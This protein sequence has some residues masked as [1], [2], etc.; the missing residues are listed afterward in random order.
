MKRSLIVAGTLILAI[1]LIV[2]HSVLVWARVPATPPEPSYIEL[3]DTPTVVDGAFAEWVLAEDGTGDFFANMIID[4]GTGGQTDILSKLYLRYDCS[5]NTLYALSLNE[6]GVIS[7]DQGIA[8]WLKIAGQSSNLIDP[9]GNFFWVGQGEISVGWEGSA[10]LNPGSYT[11]EAVSTMFAVN[12]Q[13][14][15]STGQIPL[16]IQCPG[17]P[18]PGTIIVKK[19]TDPT[20][21]LDVLFTFTGDVAGDIADGGQLVVNNLPPGT[22]TS[23]EASQAGFELSGIV[24]D[25]GNSATPSSGDLATRTATFNLDPGETVTCTFTNTQLAPP[26]PPPGTIIVKK[27]TDPA[28]L[29][30]VLFTFTGDVAGDIADGGQLVVNNLPPGTYTSTEASQAGFE[31]SGIVCD[32]GNSATPSSG[33]LATRTATFNLDPGETVTCTFTNTQLAPPPPPPGTIIV[34][35][36]TD[37]LGLTDVFTFTGDVA[38]NISDGGQLM[39]NNLPPGVYTSTEVLDGDTLRFELVSIVCDDGNSA[40]PSSGD[41]AT[42]TA[43]FNLDPGETVVCTFTNKEQDITAITLAAFEVQAND[44]HAT[45]LWQT[46]TETDN[47]GFNLYRAPS[48]DGPWVRINSALLAAQGSAVAGANYS[49]V[50]TPGR[51]TVYYRL[52]DVDY[53]GVS[54]FHGPVQAELG[55]AVRAPWYR[56]VVPR[57]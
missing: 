23:T 16:L 54:T 1:M 57:P 2:V 46:G 3:G 15:S 36:Q 6:P 43:T 9:T 28:G 20:G 25:D 8:A 42:R 35:K 53:F 18:T 56:P 48:T 21:L 38:G 17:Q 19:Q 11:F 22:Y 52:E 47:A 51:G 40:T 33:D 10:V 5:N 26:P 45:V 12:G 44:G 4:G 50:D 49:F 13:A 34:Q 39:V 41:L 30:D 7:V 14:V 31:L 32:D 55:P 24:C 29:L 37:P 27:Q